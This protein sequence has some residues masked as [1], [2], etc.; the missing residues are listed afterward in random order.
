MMNP[1]N[2]IQMLKD[3][4]PAQ[5]LMGMLRQ[6]SGNNPVMQ[7]ALDMAEKGDSKGI[8]N[9]ARNLC[10]EQGVNPDEMFNNIKNQFG[11]K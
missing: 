3:G 2:L 1:M 6:Q 7:N 8:E 4:N 5:M 9:L 10:K 11:M